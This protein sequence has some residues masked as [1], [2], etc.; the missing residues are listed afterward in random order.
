VPSPSVLIA[1]SD[2]GFRRL[3]GAALTRAGNEVRTMTVRPWRVQRVIDLHPPDVVVL[4]VDESD[5]RELNAHVAGLTT[6][7]GLVL[8][9]EDLDRTDLPAI[10]KWGPVENLVEEVRLAASLAAV[11]QQGRPRLRLIH[12]GS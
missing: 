1:S 12:G 5:G 3:A 4:D 11:G 9:A 2:P 10:D 8:I 6:P 7:P